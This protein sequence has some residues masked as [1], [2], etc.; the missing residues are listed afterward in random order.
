[1][2]NTNGTIL[3][4]ALC[5]ICQISHGFNSSDR[6]AIIVMVV[7]VSIVVILCYTGVLW[8]SIRTRTIRPPRLEV[9]MEQIVHK[10][11]T[12]E[13]DQTGPPTPI[14]TTQMV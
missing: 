2:N 14:T 10:N 3:E 7:F 6:R 11:S 8:F 12:Y 1:M 9:P 13:P 5:E 4:D